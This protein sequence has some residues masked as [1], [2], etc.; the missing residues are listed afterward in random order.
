M[1][2]LTRRPAND[3]FVCTNITCS[4]LGADEFHDAMVKAA[5][6]HDVN[7][8][9]FECL[10]ACDIA[11]MASI[12]GEYVGP[13]E[14]ADAERIVAEL[15]EGK[16]VLPEKQIRYRRTVDPGAGTSEA[17][18]HDFGTP[19]HSDRADS[20]G[21]PASEASTDRPGGS[22]PVEVPPEQRDEP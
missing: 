6:G 21:L 20:A 13:L 14:L 8:A 5:R 4:L 16:P 15:A 17:E 18:S 10:G 11:P 22:A 2:K 3:V 1:F 19:D 9:S 12:N 7:V